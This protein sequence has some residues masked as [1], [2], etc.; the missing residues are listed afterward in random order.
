MSRVD[1]ALR[2]AAAEAAPQE[3]HPHLSESQDDIETLAREPFPL[4]MPERRRQQREVAPPPP[5]QIS[6]APAPSPAAL[7]VAVPMPSVHS[8][9]AS[10]VVEVATPLLLERVD[11][12]LAGKTVVDQQQSPASREQ[13]RRLAAT[14]HHLQ[15][16][17][18]IKVV[19]ITSATM[20]EGKTLTASNL[21]MTFSESYQKR[22]LL[23]DADLR[24][25]ALH[26]VFRI[27]EGAGLSDGLMADD[28]RRLPVHQVSERLAILSA[29]RPSNDPI[30]GLTSERMR[31]VIDEAREAFDWV[32]ID[33]PP[34]TLLPDANLLGAMVDGTVLV[35]KA[36]ETPYQLVQ[37]AVDAIGRNR[38]L[39]TV[40]NRATGTDGNGYYN[41]EY[42]ADAGPG[43]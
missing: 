34:V 28:D 37:R 14:L 22:V 26:R 17:S 40:L 41:Y 8:T 4:E 11:A 1:E 10:P 25:P 23:I 21:A 38:I 24:R 27:T 42:R 15:K 31:R 6:P 2:R 13:Y 33:T 19:M 35:V 39:G 7:H 20:G 16:S 36:N 12:S 9:M 3:L 5:A 43:A 30:A 32:I 18:K 29:G